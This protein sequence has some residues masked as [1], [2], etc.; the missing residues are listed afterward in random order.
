VKN[1]LFGFRARVP[2]LGLSL[3]AVRMAQHDRAATPTGALT[4]PPT[5]RNRTKGRDMAN[6]I[7]AELKKAESERFDNPRARDLIGALAN[8]QRLACDLK[9]LQETYRHIRKSLAVIPNASIRRLETLKQIDT[10]LLGIRK[11][12]AA[13][14]KRAFDLAIGRYR[15]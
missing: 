6:A 4:T 1:D 2:L 3:A 10:Q 5:G 13:E 8:Y 14:A 11:H 15:S 12:D 7:K 9:H